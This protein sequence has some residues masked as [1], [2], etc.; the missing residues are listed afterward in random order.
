M[1]TL[2]IPDD[3]AAKA[4]QIPGLSERVARFIQLEIIQYEQRRKRFHP[5]TLDLI[6]KARRNAEALQAAG[7]NVDE[8]KQSFDQHLRELT[9]NDPPC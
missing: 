7:H 3:L 8:T 4:S 5:E 9:E 6:A 2:K 1:V